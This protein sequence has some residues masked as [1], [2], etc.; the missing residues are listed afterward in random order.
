MGGAIWPD[1]LRSVSQ[2]HSSH[3]P[4]NGTYIISYVTGRVSMTTENNENGAVTL[5]LMNFAVY[6]GHVTL[7]VLECLLLHAI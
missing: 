6:V 3:R 2:S 7:S 5:S 1:D 4:A